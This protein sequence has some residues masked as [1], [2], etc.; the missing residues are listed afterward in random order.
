[1]VKLAE[2]FKSSLVSRGPD[3]EA[4]DQETMEEMIS[5]GIVSPVTKE[6]AG[7]FG[8]MSSENHLLC[9]LHHDW[10]QVLLLHSS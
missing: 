7:W 6:N 5:M 1:M 4:P 10:K 9:Q 2:R 3:Q 8:P